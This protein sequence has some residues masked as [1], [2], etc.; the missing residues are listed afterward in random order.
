MAVSLD[1]VRGYQARRHGHRLKVR[2]VQNGSQSH[3]DYSLHV[4]RLE[5]HARPLHPIKSGNNKKFAY[6]GKF[7]WYG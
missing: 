2:R 4:R 1:V 3:V 6:E 5:I 7:G